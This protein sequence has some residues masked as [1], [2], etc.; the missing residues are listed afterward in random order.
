[1]YTTMY[2]LGAI[3]AVMTVAFRY[4]RYNAPCIRS[5][6]TESLVVI[7][8]VISGKLLFGLESLIFDGHFSLQGIRIYGLIYSVPIMCLILRRFVGLDWQN[9]LSLCTPGLALSS[10][11]A[12]VGCQIAGCCGGPP[13]LIG[14]TYIDLPE[15]LMEGSFDFILFY[16]LLVLEKKGYQ[17]WMYP[18]YLLSYAIARFML[19]FLRDSP[20]VLGNLTFAQWISIV[21]GVL[22]TIWIASIIKEL[23]KT[24]VLTR[25]DHKN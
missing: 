19:D 14:K 12:R 6:I 18:I 21:S 3:A 22:A 4:K 16:F 15:Q 13:V 25:G 7:F 2:I 24:K 11:F 10:T 9:V 20:V 23:K 5:I 1:M 17:K 8:A